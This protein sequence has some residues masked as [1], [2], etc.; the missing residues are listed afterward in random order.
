MTTAIHTTPDSAVTCGPNQLFDYLLEKLG[1]KTDAALC[2]ALEVAPPVVSKIR[3]AKLTVTARMMIK[4]HDVS[5]MS[6][7]EIRTR[8][9][10][11]A[12]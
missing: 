11:H 6:I 8:L 12:K 9:G 1:L 5:G 10:T 7:S 4:I 3:H 2:R